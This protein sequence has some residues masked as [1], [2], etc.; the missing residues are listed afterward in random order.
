MLKCGHVVLFR[1]FSY[2]SIS[3]IFILIIGMSGILLVDAL[4]FF[5]NYNIIDFLFGTE[6]EPNDTHE[7][8][9]GLLPVLFG[10]LVVMIVSIV[11]SL[12]LSLIGALY[13]CEYSSP[14]MK[15]IYKISFEI[16]AGLPTLMY[17]C[18]GVYVLSPIF[19]DIC[20]VFHIY[21]SYENAF[22]AG[23]TVGLM[24]IPSLL[25]LFTK[26]LESTCRD[27]KNA[28]F[29]LG[30][31]QY[32]AIMT[33]IIPSSKNNILSGLLFAFSR[34]MGETIIVILTAGI[35][36]KF[37]CNP[38]ESISTITVQMVRLL[39]GDQ[40]MEST[41]SYSAYA[42]GL[43]LFIITWITNIFAKKIGNNTK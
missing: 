6:W 39:T 41:A 12:P 9:F 4:K 13:V 33:V 14:K 11:I 28:S 23:V 2:I 37:T 38:L 27:L 3:L 10:S 42:L 43:T 24:I 30:A 31:T 8:K 7:P 19:H 20:T 40:V 15:T 1:I 29:A 17:G 34:A 32:E 25:S 5:Y 36:A 26:S 18:F 22:I 35:T 16:L 21:T